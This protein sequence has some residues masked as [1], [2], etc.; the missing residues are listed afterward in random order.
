MRLLYIC[1]LT[2]LISSCSPYGHIN[3]EAKK[4]A[5]IQIPKDTKSVCFVI[6]QT[7]PQKIHAIIDSNPKQKELYK[8][9]LYMNNICFEGFYDILNE[10]NRFDRIMYYK[11]DVEVV[12]DSIELKPLNWIQVGQICN[13]TGSDILVVLEKSKFSIGAFDNTIIS[14]DYRFRCYDPYTF[15]I[16][17]DSSYANYKSYSDNDDEYRYSIQEGKEIASYKLGEQYAKQITPEIVRI[18]RLYYNKGNNLLRLGSYYLEQ[19]QYN[20]ALSVWKELIDNSKDKEIAYKACINISLAEEMRY[21]FKESIKY[22]SLSLHYIDKQKKSDEYKE[23]SSELIKALRI[24]N[25]EYK[26]RTKHE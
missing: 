16:I 3:F 20:K 7:V 11:T 10:T 22:A 25:K 17:N 5:K 2:I 13:K 6:R 18:E 26:I 9:N 21:N 24:R 12:T 19:K 8:Y 14:W 15:S 23:F 1:L 4:P